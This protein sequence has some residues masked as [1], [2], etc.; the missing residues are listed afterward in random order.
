ML[1]SEEA[2]RRLG[3]KVATL[4][5]YVSRGMLES[6]RAPDGKRSL[7]EVADIEQLAARSREGR[8]VESRLATITTRVTQ[9][10]DGGPFYRGRAAV[11]LTAEMTYEEVAA[12]L[13]E[14]E[15]GGDWTAPPFGRLGPCPLAETSDRMR[16]ALVMCGADDPLR[17]DLRPESVHR[18]ARRVIAALVDVVGEAPGLPR[19]PGAAAEGGEGDGDG[20]APIALRL[21]H[22]LGGHGPSLSAA[23]VDAALILMADHELATST[24]AVRLAASTRADVYD[25]LLAGLATLAGPLHGGASQQAYELLVSAERDGVPRALNDV[26]RWNRYLPGFGHTIYMVSD[27]RFEALL[28]LAEPLLSEDRRSM[29]H[30]VMALA[31][32]HDVPAPNCDLALAALS[33]GTGMP[34]DA[35]RT[36][37][38]VARIA[39][40]TAHYLEEL[41]ERPLRFRAR[42][43]YSV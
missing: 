37:F 42:A 38:T 2:A 29:L 3:V 31:L 13:W 12:L 39:G 20:A 6:H 14:G 22:R 30:E 23:A 21:A 34:P 16:W 15:A 36:I 27:P 8:Q 4:Y 11:S 33:W 5:A 25:A 7:F 1:Q 41:G 9:L 40:W 19:S 10:R 17:A 18:A 35:G 32:E 26:L 43:V 24:M 28:A